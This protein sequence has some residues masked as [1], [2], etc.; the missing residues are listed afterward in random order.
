MIKILVAEDEER[1]R[2]L[3]CKYLN[4]EGYHAVQAKDGKEALELFYSSKYNLVLLDIMM[5]NVDGF[6]VCSE[7]RKTSDI[8]IIMITARNTE[9][10]EL[11]G[12]QFGAD[13][14]ITKPFSSKILVSRVAAILKRT[15]VL[16]KNESQVGNIKVIY[17]EHVAYDGDEKIPLTPREYDLLCYFLENKEQVLSREQILEGV[18]GIDYEGDIRTVDTHVK[19]LRYKMP[20]VHKYLKTIRKCGYIFEE[21]N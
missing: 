10:D 2:T 19:C 5:P 13:E 17:R 15:G 21:T 8:P 4:Q 12:F 9:Y 14:Y 1:L 11:T 6:E 16:R 7:I 3:I 20:S 18:W